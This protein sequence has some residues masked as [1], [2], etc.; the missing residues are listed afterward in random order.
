MQKHTRIYFEYFGYGID[1]FVSCEICGAKAADIHHINGRG[2]G[3]DNIFNLAALCRECHRKVH[4]GKI[5]KMVVKVRH[6][7]FMK[8]EAF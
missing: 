4:E 5:H 1:S 6:D 3:K 2:K 8:K 7:M